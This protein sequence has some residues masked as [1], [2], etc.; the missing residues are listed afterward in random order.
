MDITTG[1]PWD[2]LRVL[3]ALHR[4]GSFLAVGR[5]LGISTSTAARR[6]DAL[7]AALGRPLVQRTRSGT[8]IEPDALPLVALAEQLELGLSALRR[9]HVQ[10]EAAHSGV[11]RL[12]VGE[13]FVRPVVG[14]LSELRRQHPGLQFELISES[15]FA[16]LSRREA[17][18]AIRKAKTDSPSLIERSAGKLSFGLYVARS[19]LDRRLPAA[20]VDRAE[21]AR[22]DLIGYDGPLARTTPGQW[23]AE[24]GAKCFAFRSNSDHAIEEAIQQGQGIGLLAKAHARTL[25]SLVE[26]R[27]DAP[28]PALPVYLVFHKELRNVARHRL[29]V[30]ALADALRK[31]LA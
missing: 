30:S 12:S 15:R 28:L 26:L 16:D 27:Y 29:V 4:Q 18:I 24:Q 17:D 19:Y 25:P 1:A 3:L 8:S 21:L 6:I 10:S 9:D 2:D 31:A 11:V 5:T 7:E 22:H 23:W 13:G 20:R 14:L